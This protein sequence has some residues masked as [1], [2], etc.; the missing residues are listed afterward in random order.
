MGHG[1][2]SVGFS[3]FYFHSKTK[4]VHSILSKYKKISCSQKRQNSKNL[5]DQLLWTKNN[6]YLWKKIRICCSISW[7]Y[8]K[9]LNW[10]RNSNYLSFSAIFTTRCVFKFIFLSIKQKSVEKFI[11]KFRLF[12]WDNFSANCTVCTILRGGRKNVWSY[13]FFMASSA[14]LGTSKI[15]DIWRL[16]PNFSTAP[17][18]IP[19][20]NRKSCK[21]YE[22]LAFCRKKA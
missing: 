9:H 3:Y 6:W 13:L 22:K 2:H 19:I 7:T 18:H 1:S 12:Y 11:F 16:D 15:T 21:M 4:F 10:Y 8:Y 5:A 17:N 14:P 20:P